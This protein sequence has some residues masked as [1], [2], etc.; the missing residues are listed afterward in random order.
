[1]AARGDLRVRVELLLDGN[2]TIMSGA[3]AKHVCYV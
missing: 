2:C 1:M 3:V